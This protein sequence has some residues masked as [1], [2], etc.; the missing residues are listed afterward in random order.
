MR[1][2]HAVLRQERDIAGWAVAKHSLVL[3]LPH[4]FTN[5]PLY[6]LVALTPDRQRADETRARSEI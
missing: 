6:G 5:P 4:D 1:R 2:G 3:H